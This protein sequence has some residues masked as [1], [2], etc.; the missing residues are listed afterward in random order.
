M[1]IKAGIKSAFIAGASLLFLVLAG[2]NVSK[3]A[4]AETVPFQSASSLSSGGSSIK[5]VNADYFRKNIFDY[6]AS[7]NKFVYK[8][9]KP[10]I[11]DFYADWCGPCRQL[12]PKLEEV[13]KKYK[14]KLIVYKVNIDNETELARIFGVRSIPMCLF[15]PKNGTPIQT[16]GNLPM[17]EI[18]KTIAQIM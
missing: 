13:A 10:A 18:E 4:K 8:G 2:Y 16:M 15:I 3:E 5:Y 1:K 17:N 14:G 6:S 9:D 7:P 11:V 12:S